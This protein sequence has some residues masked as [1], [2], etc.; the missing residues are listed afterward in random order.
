M[1]AEEDM[2][3]K[4]LEA[5]KWAVACVCVCVCV[6]VRTRVRGGR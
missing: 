4:E 6:C 1:Q 2:E 3:R 5:I